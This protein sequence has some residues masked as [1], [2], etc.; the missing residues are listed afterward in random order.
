[1][2][3]VSTSIV[4]I[5]ALLPALA[6]GANEEQQA[7]WFWDLVIALIV[8]LAALASAALP[9]AA[10]R[11]WP[12]AWRWGALFPFAVLLAW[13]SL[14]AAAKLMDP[15]AHG[16]WPLELFAWAMLNMIYMVALM[17]TKRLF[18]KADA[19]ASEP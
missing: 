13:G 1:M 16:L 14:I 8:L 9:I 11:N 3:F 7:V 15:T 2:R 19:E 6:L 17:T 4:V 10:F 5:S 18:E 12:N